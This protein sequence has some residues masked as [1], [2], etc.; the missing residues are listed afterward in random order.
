LW[1]KELNH[2]TE[3]DT[4]NPSD[5]TGVILSRPDKNTHQ[6]ELNKHTNKK[7]RGVDGSSR[8]GGFFCLI[9][10]PKSDPTDQETSITM[11][12][13]KQKRMN[14]RVFAIVTLPMAIG[15]GK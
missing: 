11:L 8:A 15:V 3:K 12:R 10:F 4:Y 9:T 14:L 1:Q 2:K 6:R 5:H 7:T 13:S